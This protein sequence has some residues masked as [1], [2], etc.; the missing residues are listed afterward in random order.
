MS[1]ERTIEERT[2][3]LLEKHGLV[4]EAP[5]ESPDENNLVPLDE[6]QESIDE[7]EETEN[8]PTD[9]EHDSEYT[10]LNSEYSTEEETEEE[11]V[12]EDEHGEQEPQPTDLAPIEERLGNLTK[13]IPKTQEQ[14]NLDNP[15]DKYEAAKRYMRD[16]EMSLTQ[17]S[18]LEGLGEFYYEGKSIYEMTESEFN[19]VIEELQSNANHLEV[20][21]YS[22][23]RIEATKKAQEW[24][25]KKT[26][27]ERGRA[28]LEALR[29]ESEWYEVGKQWRDALPELTDDMAKELHGYI[30]Q[31]Y[32][33]M[34]DEFTKVTSDKQKKIGMINEAFVKLRLM[35]RIKPQGDT[36][37]VAAPDSKAGSKQHKTKSKPLT[38]TRKQ[39]ET[40]SD[41]EFRK[42]ESQIN[43]AMSK[44]L[45]S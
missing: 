42:Y 17:T 41:A 45:V 37:Q 44:G 1:E 18:P 31:Q 15:V 23:A 21:R 39:I 11:T 10:E 5:A 8:N 24:V 32:V 13:D 19:D 9:N 22:Q 6:Q 16:M 20:S 33:S 30:N 12:S 26:E 14:L 4:D 28:G 25:N 3:E 2:Q 29:H 34:G 38:F 35:D 7:S 36:T 40:M 43:E 27:F